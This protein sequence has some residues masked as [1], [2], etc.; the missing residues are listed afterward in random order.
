MG[1]DGLLN[2]TKT[3]V[4]EQQIAASQTVHFTAQGFRDRY[5][6]WSAVC[7]IPFSMCS[8]PQFRDMM[9]YASP[10]LRNND[11]LP[12]SGS[13]T[14]LLM[15]EL[16]KL[17]QAVLI[18]SLIASNCQLHL[19]F[20]L[21]TSPNNYS[22]LGIVGHFIDNSFKAR[23][24]LL[25]LKRLFGPHS[26][27]NIAS[28][29]TTILTTY[30]LQNRL[31]FC[32]MDNA[33][34]NNTAL[35]AIE[36]FLFDLGIHWNG[37]A[38]RL[39]CLGHVISLI[40]NAFTENKPLK[41]KRVR[42]QKGTPKVKWERPIDAITKLHIIIVFIMITS[43]RI[44]EFKAINTTTDE[45][46]LLPIQENLTR[47][48]STYLML[49]RALILRNSID[50]FAIRYRESQLGKRDEKNLSDVQMGA[51]DWNYAKEVVDFLKPLYYIVKHVEGKDED[52]TAIPLFIASK[53]ANINRQLRLYLA[54]YSSL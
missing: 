15:L 1:P 31:G 46:F 47:W 12:R 27:K 26:G 28:L 34:D 33:S 43:Q 5:L 41:S 53:T 14:K 49:L 40:A 7:H 30:Q 24:V 50:L 11:T 52:G 20:D 39:R 51:S 4:Y 38:H 19:S 32:I 45:A 21:W 22:M 18:Q 10:S 35:E 25:G 13:T 23:T 8:N 48:F 54:D 44:E 42:R 9:E 16:F 6:Y 17:C 2:T 3:T 37:K 36:Q 29:V